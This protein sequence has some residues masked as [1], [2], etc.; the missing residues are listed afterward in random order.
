M[1]KNIFLLED[2]PAVPFY[3]IRHGETDWNLNKLC[4]GRKDIPLN[5]NGIKSAYAA[6]KKLSNVSFDLIF[7]SPLLRAKQT[8]EILSKELK[9]DFEIAEEFAERGFGELEGKSSFLMYEFEK[10]ETK[11]N[12]SEDFKDLKVEKIEDLQA[13]IKKGL[14]NILDPNLQILLVSHGRLF[15]ALNQMLSIKLINQIQNTEPLL[16]KPEKGYWEIIDQ[17]NES[18][19][20]FNFKID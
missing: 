13:R 11:G 9:I 1:K 6:A 4:Q 14:K 17:S 10:Q 7:T 8:A 19:P 3:F 15:F 20:L 12:I 16:I 18:F 5:T 2:I